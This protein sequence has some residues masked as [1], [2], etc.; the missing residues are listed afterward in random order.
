MATIVNFDPLETTYITES[1]HRR[2]FLDAAVAAPLPSP[3]P[4]ATK[5]ELVFDL[6]EVRRGLQSLEEEYRAFAL[7]CEE[8]SRRL[9]EMNPATAP[10][11]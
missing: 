6:E 11:N 10:G 8:I 4:V 3:I 5:V 1:T 9:A 2:R 7:E